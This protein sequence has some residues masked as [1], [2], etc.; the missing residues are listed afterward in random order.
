MTSDTP[1]TDAIR[2]VHPPI[3][4]VASLLQEYDDLV[5]QLERELS[6]AQEV[7]NRETLS[8]AYW[9]DKAEKAQR[10]AARYRWLRNSHNQGAN[11]PTSEGLM[12]V[13]DRPAKE[14]RYIG[15]LVWQLLDAAID[16]AMQEG[17]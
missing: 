16:S 15:P 12:V 6:I 4:L 17:K 14:P 13:T 5:E 1:R 11:S 9:K 3:Y 8:A 7:A 10:D 2:R